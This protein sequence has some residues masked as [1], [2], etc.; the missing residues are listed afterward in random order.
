MQHRWPSNAVSRVAVMLNRVAIFADLKDSYCIASAKARLGVASDL[1]YHEVYGLT[2][3]QL[4]GSCVPDD[5]AGKK[6]EPQ[7]L[8]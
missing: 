2:A 3:T 8:P 4:D 1:R 5:Q 6:Q 7:S